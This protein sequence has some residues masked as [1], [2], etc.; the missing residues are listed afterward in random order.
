M[1]FQAVNP[2]LNLNFVSNCELD[3]RLLT[4]QVQVQ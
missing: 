3:Q 4:K 1:S 2:D